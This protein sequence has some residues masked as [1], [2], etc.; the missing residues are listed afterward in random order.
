[1]HEI[2]LILLCI[3]VSA[4]PTGIFVKK[5]IADAPAIVRP[6]F[7]RVAQ[8]ATEPADAN[9]ELDMEMF[10]GLSSDIQDIIRKYI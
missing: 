4:I 10:E 5:N 6:D 9:A 7:E 8:P 3:G 2:I 1:M